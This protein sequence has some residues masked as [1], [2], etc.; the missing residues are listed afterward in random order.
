MLSLQK[1]DFILLISK[2][3]LLKKSSQP[4]IALYFEFY[5]KATEIFPLVI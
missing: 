5:Q 2:H 3:L 4:L 1:R